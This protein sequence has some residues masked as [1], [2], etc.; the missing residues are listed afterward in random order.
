MIADANLL[1]IAQI[2]VTQTVIGAV[3]AWLN[4]PAFVVRADR[5][6]LL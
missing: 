6:Q 1:G 5:V 2:A 3:T 4:F